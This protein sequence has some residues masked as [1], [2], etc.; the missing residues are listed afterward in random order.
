MS[1]QSSK[2]TAIGFRVRS[3][4]DCLGLSQD[5]LAVALGFK[6]RQTVS[7]IEQGKRS[8]KAEELV[9][10]S[11]ALHKD[12]EFFID[13]FNVAGE[14]SFSWRV[15]PTVSP[16]VLLNF[17][18]RAG[19]TV[20]LLRWL[21]TLDKGG[22]S[23]LK[24][25]LRLSIFSSF[26]EAQARAEELAMKMAPGQIPSCRLV[27]Y[28]EKE[29]DLPVIFV[30]IPENASISGSCC[31]LA[32]LGVVI[33]NRHESPKRRNF[34]LAHELFHAL[35]WESM[36][37]AHR[38]SNSPGDQNPE[39]QDKSIKNKKTIRIEQLANNFAAALLMPKYQLDVMVDKNHLDDTGHLADVANRLRVNTQ[40]FGWRLY[41]LG[42]ITPEVR[43]ALTYEN[44]AHEH[45]E[46]P[47]PFSSTLI[48]SLGA[49]ITNGKI[50]PRKAAKAL[51][52]SLSQLVDVFLQYGLPDPLQF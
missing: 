21:R 33:V 13:P 34:D 44:G 9:K 26:E 24:S 28:M 19:K 32:D 45:N 22:H 27:E 15:S 5:Q 18:S 7:D 36:P 52:L 2:P 48:A 1:D 29:L 23:P 46:I 49:A 50:S 47:K 35:T 30:D 10:V 51:G 38:E 37:P 3:A 8:L 14:A 11:E 6:D 41:N 4:R 25:S 16:E 17:E 12:I 42:W 39:S 20:G 40:A 43:S 31:H